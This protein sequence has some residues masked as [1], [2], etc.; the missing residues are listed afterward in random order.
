[1]WEMAKGAAFR[2]GQGYSIESLPNSLIFFGSGKVA[3]I[4]V[5]V[6]ILIVLFV[7]GYF[8]L[9]YTSFGRSVY[10]T[11]GNPA[12]AW[13]SGIN[14]KKIQFLVYVISGLLAGVSGAMISARTMR[15]SMQT[16][17]G[18]EI[19]S[20]AAVT[21]GGVSL[22]GGRG[23]VIGVLIGV[24]IIGVINNG[25][26]ILRTSPELQGVVKGAVIIAAVAADYLRR[27]R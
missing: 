18:L 9:H 16:L 11:G 17:T 24:F 21:I 20:I 10:A 6:I 22:M 5:P 25:M 12:S 15:A 19:D 13:L 7:I 26:S 23:T 27:R 2:V 1:M 3:G 14:V 4:P 8:I